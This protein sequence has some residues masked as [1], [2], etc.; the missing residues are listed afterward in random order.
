M[1]GDCTFSDHFAVWGKLQLQASPPRR[2]SYKMSGRYLSD[3]QVRARISQIWASNQTKSFFGK[4]KLV[5]KFYRGYCIEAAKAQRVEEAH[6]RSQ[7]AEAVEELHADPSNEGC[8]SRLSDIGERLGE[9]ERH[10]IEGLKI[11]NRVR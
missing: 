1:R 3:N 7:L 4:L 5:M 6:L 9:V 11:R 2:S 10:H 8:Q